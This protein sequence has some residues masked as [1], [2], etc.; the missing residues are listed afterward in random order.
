MKLSEL[1]VTPEDGGADGEEFPPPSNPMAVA[2]QLLLAWQHDGQFILRHWRGSWMSWRRSHWAELDDRE[3]RSLAYQRLEHAAYIHITPKGEA[4]VRSWAPSKRKISDLLEAQAAIV[5][6]PS[7]VDAPSWVTTDQRARV[8]GPVVACANGLLDVANRQL[9]DHDPAFFNLVSVPFGYSADA[10]ASRWREFLAQLWP[11]DSDQIAAL[12]EWFGYVVSGRTDLHKIL[13]I[14]G[15]TRSG[16]GTIARV[17]TAMIGKANMA[18]PTL[19]SLGTNFGLSP[20]LGKPLAVI[21]DARLGGRDTHQVVERLLT[22]S[23]E[24]SIDVDR[25]Y[26][27]PWTGRLPTRFMILSNELPHFGDASGTIANRFIVLNTATSWLGHEDIT[28]AD[29]LMAELPGILNWAL[30]GLE[31]L[32]KQGRFTEPASSADAVT[33]MQDMASPVSAFVRERCDIGSDKQIVVDDLWVAWRNW[34]EDN[35]GKPGTK[36]MLGRNLRS[37]VPH[38][39][40]TRPHGEKR[41]YDGIDLKPDSQQPDNQRWPHNGRTAGSSGSADHEKPTEPQSEPSSQSSDLRE[42]LEPA[43][44]AIVG[45][46]S[47][48]PLTEPLCPTCGRHLSTVEIG[49]CGHCGQQCHRYGDHTHGTLCHQCGGAT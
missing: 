39:K 2:R 15:P 17:L 40:I 19:A 49:P 27:D 23:G 13:L 32:E 38:L 18:G 12:Q 33:T 29:E 35:G 36:T 45:P 3:V 28:L 22:V 14:V 16:K 21:S 47:R 1:D 43:S 34:C 30:D 20:L 48:E 37:T 25:K 11:K 41:R 6:L 26:K 44:E 42:P 10:D 9:I 7:S 5:H 46:T 4:E 8:S 24:D 31:R